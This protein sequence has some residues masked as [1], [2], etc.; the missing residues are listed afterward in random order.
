MSGYEWI[1]ALLK[2]RSFMWVSIGSYRKFTG[3]VASIDLIYLLVLKH[4]CMFVKNINLNS[5]K[6][7][8]CRVFPLGTGGDD[9]CIEI[10]C[11]YSWSPEDH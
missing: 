10:C 8:T 2:P 6:K 11:A 5:K 9:K 3:K 7:I 1:I 4:Q